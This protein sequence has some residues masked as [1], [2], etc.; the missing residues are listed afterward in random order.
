MW[1]SCYIVDTVCVS[2]TLSLTSEDKI[3]MCLVD[4]KHGCFNAISA[5]DDYGC[6]HLIQPSPD[7][8]CRQNLCSTCSQ[9]GR[10]SVSQEGDLEWCLCTCKYITLSKY[11][12]VMFTT[13]SVM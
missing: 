4:A 2:C 7:S 8:Y 1:N 10:C 3:P 11:H 9:M 5:T 6:V 12:T 13:S